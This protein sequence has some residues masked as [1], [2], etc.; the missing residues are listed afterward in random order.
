M[1]SG[2]PFE[3]SK[4][5]GH[6]AGVVVIGVCVAVVLAGLVAVARWGGLTVEPPRAPGQANPP[7][8]ADP[9]DQADRQ[10]RRTRPSRP[11]G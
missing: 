11:S 4:R 5:D 1:A 6:T 8:E 10:T 2:R 3:L 9:A 7:A